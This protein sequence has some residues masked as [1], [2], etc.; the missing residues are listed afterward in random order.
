[1]SF[2][3]TNIFLGILFGGVGFVAWRYGRHK[4]S[5][6]HMLLAVI[7][8]VFP[9]FLSNIWVLLLVGSG[10]TFFLFWP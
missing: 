3:L 7:L 6:R 4:Q 10:L 2:D 8:M 5:A 1:M 9:Y